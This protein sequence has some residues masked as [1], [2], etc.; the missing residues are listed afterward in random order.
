MS[1]NN[2]SYIALC[3][4]QMAMDG[5]SAA[6]IEFFR[7]IAPTLMSDGMINGVMAAEL[8]FMTPQGAGKH[9]KNMTA[10]SY[11]VRKNRRRWELADRFIRHK[12]LIPLTRFLYTDN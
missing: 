4:A 6:T 12:D 5:N 10:R 3:V 2:N 8:T 11:L 7:K 9:I 1:M